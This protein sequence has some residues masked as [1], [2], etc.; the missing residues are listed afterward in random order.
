MLNIN[1]EASVYYQWILDGKD[2]LGLLLRS[3]IPDASGSCAFYEITSDHSWMDL[4]RGYP[5]QNWEPAILASEWGGLPSGSGHIVNRGG[6]DWAV[7]PVHREDALRGLFISDDAKDAIAGAEHVQRLFSAVYAWAD[8]TQPEDPWK[9]AETSTERWFVCDKKG[10]SWWNESMY[11]WMGGQPVDGAPIWP[12]WIHADSPVRQ[13]AFWLALTKNETWSGTVSGDDENKPMWWQVSSIESGKFIVRVNTYDELSANTLAKAHWQTHDSLTGLPRQSVMSPSWKNDG[14]LEWTFAVWAVDNFH[15][16]NQAQGMVVG[17]KV[18]ELAANTIN[19]ALPPGWHLW[20]GRAETFYGMGPVLPGNNDWY[21]QTLTIDTSSSGVPDIKCSIGLSTGQDYRTCLLAAQEALEYAQASNG[22]Q[23]V[24]NSSE[25]RLRTPNAVASAVA[26]MD[27]SV[28]C[29]IVYLPIMT[30]RSPERIQAFEALL[31]WHH[32]YWGILTPDMFWREAERTDTIH[33]IGPW[34]IN[35]LLTQI[36]AWQSMGHQAIEVHANVSAAQI[37]NPAFTDFL[38]EAVS[39]FDWNG[40]KLMLEIPERDVVTA[41]DAWRKYQ[42]RWEK[43]GI[44]IVLDDWGV[45]PTANSYL[46]ELCVDKIKLSASLVS[47]MRDARQRHTLTGMVSWLHH[48]GYSVIADGVE[49]AEV[50][51]WAIEVGCDAYQGYL[52]NRDRKVVRWKK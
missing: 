32:P 4:A 23:A 14:A 30:T 47:S 13:V 40:A 19:R 33:R 48:C 2:P 10:L 51:D 26:V 37:Q 28:S 46:S 11:A 34:M 16:L 39:G 8:T 20:R 52:N 41:I 9:F 38:T 25:R 27:P 42:P 17:D 35:T 49:S 24:W 15:V 18:L 29:N 43:L 3:C 1:L 44:G 21:A 5:E 12:N 36:K 45:G 50:K 31:R 7:I 22:N 6:R